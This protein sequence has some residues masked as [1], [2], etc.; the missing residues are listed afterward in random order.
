VAATQ[1]HRQV[2]DDRLTRHARDAIGDAMQRASPR[3]RDHRRDV[4]KGKYTRNRFEEKFPERFFERR[5]LLN[6][7]RVAFSPPSKPKTGNA[8]DRRYLQQR[9]AT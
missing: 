2:K 5:D 3:Q 8:S 1:S 4:A 6:R 7:T 9:P